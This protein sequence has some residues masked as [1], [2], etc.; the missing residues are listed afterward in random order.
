MY[1]W[2]AGA[3]KSGREGAGKGA[4]G[5]GASPESVSARFLISV[6]GPGPD[7]VLDEM[8]R[9]LENI[10]RNQRIIHDSWTVPS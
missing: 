10:Q 4:S 9:G 7:R 3:A 2:T 6:N 8:R 5:D 1:K